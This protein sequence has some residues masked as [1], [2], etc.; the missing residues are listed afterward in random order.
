MS[1]FEMAERPPA[2]E[3][4][5]LGPPAFDFGPRFFGGGGGIRV[6]PHAN[7]VITAFVT[8]ITG[9]DDQGLMEASY[10]ERTSYQAAVFEALPTALLDIAERYDVLGRDVFNGVITAPDVFHWIAE[11]GGEL[12]ALGLC[13]FR[14]PG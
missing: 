14:K 6:S 2:T 4:G 3:A 12:L 5:G 9:E 1:G 7:H 8:S 11:T 10:A 13:P